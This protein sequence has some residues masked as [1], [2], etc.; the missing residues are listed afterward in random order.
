MISKRLEVRIPDV[1][2]DQ[3]G[4]E[5][6]ELSNRKQDCLSAIAT[7]I[8]NQTRIEALSD[9]I[10]KE[11]HLLITGKSEDMSVLEFLERDL[12]E[13]VRTEGSLINFY[14]L[15]AKLEA[16]ASLESVKSLNENLMVSLDY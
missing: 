10:T 1:S 5:N 3:G 9:T 14:T 4:Q 7:E 8:A 15:P 6:K 13:A 2:L 16:D 12:L 11:L